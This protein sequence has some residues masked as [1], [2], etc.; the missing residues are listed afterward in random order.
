MEP[1]KVTKS[2]FLKIQCLSIA[3]IAVSSLRNDHEEADDRMMYHLNQLIKDEGFEKVVIAS[4]DADIFIC[5]VYHFN[6]WIYC[7]LKEMWVISGKSGSTTGK[8]ASEIDK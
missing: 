6:R 4:A 3:V 7:G 1:V 2:N 5:A 8:F